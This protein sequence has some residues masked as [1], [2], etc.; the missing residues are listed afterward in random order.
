M[1]PI[2][3]SP[4]YPVLTLASGKQRPGEA[5]GTRTRPNKEPRAVRAVQPVRKPAIMGIA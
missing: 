5:L 3:I 1:R 4:A 2:S